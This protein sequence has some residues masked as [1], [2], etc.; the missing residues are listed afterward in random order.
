MYNSV[1]NQK[2]L[3]AFRAAEYD[4]LACRVWH[5]HVPYHL[6]VL[7]AHQNH[8][9]LRVRRGDRGFQIDERETRTETLQTCQAEQRECHTCPTCQHFPAWF[10]GNQGHRIPHA[11]PRRPPMCAQCDDVPVIECNNQYNVINVYNL[12]KC[13]NI[14][15]MKISPLHAPIYSIQ[16]P[17]TAP[18]HRQQ[19]WTPFRC[20][21]SDQ[22]PMPCRCYQSRFQRRHPHPLSGTALPYI[23]DLK[24]ISLV[25]SVWWTRDA[26]LF[27]I[28][29]WL[30]LPEVICLSQR[31]RRAK[32]SMTGDDWESIHIR[33]GH[34][35]CKSKVVL[36]DVNLA[37]RTLRD[38]LSS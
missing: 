15:S 37:K 36:I 6:E 7:H 13:Y 22:A 24:T 19:S 21:R 30:I 26:D 27:W 31:L 29:T 2:Y 1:W 10:C 20:S 9:C 3:A 32:C 16:S 35:P 17:Y 23:S 8:F 14:Y 4:I 18:H 34:R 5:I 28:V 38:Q 33:C 25:E 11:G 12:H